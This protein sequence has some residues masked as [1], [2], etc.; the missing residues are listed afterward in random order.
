MSFL[1]NL[2]PNR[3]R[4][5]YMRSKSILSSFRMF[6][7]QRLSQKMIKKHRLL[8]ITSSHRRMTLMTPTWYGSLKLRAK[9]LRL[10]WTLKL[11][12]SSA[13]SW[14][15]WRSTCLQVLRLA[16]CWSVLSCCT[17]APTHKTL[18]GDTPRT[19][20]TSSSSPSY[21]WPPISRSKLAKWKPKLTFGKII[22]KRS[23]STKCWVLK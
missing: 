17:P 3:L 5:W 2:R 12:S 9:R 15:A 4:R 10:S 20:F 16:T 8:T 21:A 14:L 1:P 13:C 7:F 22:K 23:S 6:L 19:S 11:S 18:D